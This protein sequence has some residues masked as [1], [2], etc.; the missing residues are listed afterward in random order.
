M[1]Q[2]IRTNG[3]LMSPRRFFR[4]SPLLAGAAILSVLGAARAV[5]SRADGGSAPPI[6]HGQPSLGPGVGA[7]ANRLVVRFRDDAAPDAIQKLNRAL[8]VKSDKAHGR[9]G[10]HGIEFP[11]GTDLQAVLDAY[12]KSGLV[13]VAG[14]D[15]IAR[16]FD[17]PNDPNYPL[18]WDLQ[19]TDGGMWAEGAWALAPNPGQGV[20]V[21]VIDTGVAFEQY[22]A[23]A[24]FFPQHF[25]PAPDL[26]G[27]TFVAPHNFLNNTVHA[28]DDN[29][30]GTHVTGTIAQATNN[31][32]GVAGIANRASVMP[33]KILDYSGSGSAADL[34]EA[35]YYATDNGAKVINMSLG[36]SGTGAP[37]ANGEVCTEIVGLGAALDNA[38]DHGV[39]VVAASGNDGGTTVACPAAYPTVVAVGATRFDGQVTFYSNQ[40]SELDITAPGGDPNVDQ[41]GDGHA[42]GILQ[43]TYC[44]DWLTLLLGGDYSQF[45]DV[46]LEGTSMASPHVAATAALL[47]GQNG[48][49]TP[50]Q[51]RYYL[52]STARDRGAAGWDSAYGWGALDATAALTALAGGPPPNITPA[53]RPSPTP[54]PGPTAPTNLLVTSVAATTVQLAWT[55]N[56]ST[57]TGFKIE[58]SASGGNFVQIATVGANITTYSS[59]YL[60]PNTAYSYRVR[61][62]DATYNSLYSN[63][64]TATT[65]P[66]PP[67]PSNL[68]ASAL[69]NSSIQLTWT[70]NATTETGYRIERSADGVS[71]LQIGTVGADVV[72]YT[73]LYLTAGTTYY[74]RVRAYDGLA[75]G[76]Y[77]AVATAA[78]LP[79]PAAPGGL[80]ATPLSVSSITLTWTDNSPTETGFKIERSTDSVAYTQVATVGAGVTAYTNLYLAAG[81]TYYYRVRAYEGTANSGYSNVASATTLP[82]PPA[83]SSLSATALSATS[84]KLTWADNSTT[85]TGFKIERSTDGV[86]FSQ[87]GSVGA[88]VTSYT[89]SSL[90]AA[91]MYFFRVRAYEG[92]ANGGYSNVASAT[93]LPPPPAPSS[94]SATALSATSIKLTWT[95]NSTTE[96]GFKIERSLDGLSWAQVGTVGANVVG[97]TNTNLTPSTL[98]SFRVRAYDG[99]ANGDYS[100][101]ATATTADPPAAPS[102]LVVIA[103]TTTS[104]KLTWTDNSTNETYF[105]V[106]RSTDGVTW[107]QAATLVA[108]TTTWTNYSLISG[109]TYYFRVRALAGTS[110]YSDYSNVATV[111]MP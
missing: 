104:A 14:F 105:R 90:L 102:N 64:A 106:E 108:N 76:D 109:T 46:F 103:L 1:R 36:F 67:A 12:R 77:S 93:T 21:A 59:L 37:D 96:T 45:C 57:E 87:V 54:A 95:D 33:L 49:L 28:D 83:P 26:A 89:A 42:D 72:S 70:D 5:S 34:V 110:V 66:R 6:V 56:A 31:N 107:T 98:Y 92:S 40:G 44:V 82:P 41:N 22:N 51:V 81:T 17:A 74:F 23:A 38:F 43:E 75:N 3:D 47:L 20:V 88:N 48:A 11:D 35:I 63:V 10:L 27:V 97:Y 29:G 50:L 94:L 85:E 79:P 24:G 8:G 58:R 71:Y 25:S 68:V 65:L 15:F 100:N 60:S 91:T 69:S 19:N 61:A 16:A 111:T 73:S 39:V 52:E 13:Q 53:P 84:I 55:D 80:V 78:T 18:Q 2:I 86:S 9:S 7:S 101:V 30:H 4:F 32:Y 62:Y 99:T